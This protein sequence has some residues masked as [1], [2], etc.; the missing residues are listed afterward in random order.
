MNPHILVTYGTKY[1][2][3]AGIAEKIAEVLRQKNLHVDVLPVERV[4]EVADYDV[5]VLGSAVY[6][7]N[8]RK[9][10]AHFLESHEVWLS[11]H[12]VWLFSS[13]PMG[14][15]EPSV[16]MKGWRF[17]ESLQPVADRIKPHDIAFF[18]GLLDMDKLNIAER[19][20]VKG[21][22]SPVGDFRD[23]DVIE[24]WAATIAS[25]L[26]PQVSP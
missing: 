13:G 20:I 11:Q 16:L 2:A 14:E 26:Q 18:H 10:A 7:G 5:V 24:E 6:A 1:G 19:F 3:T 9:E 4:E 25:V 8:W 15:E 21:F 12:P 22:R 17:P 23:W